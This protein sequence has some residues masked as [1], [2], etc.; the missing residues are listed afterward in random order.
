MR[1]YIKTVLQHPGIAGFFWRAGFNAISPSHLAYE[2]LPRHVE[3]G[4]QAGTLTVG[5]VATA[6]DII[7]GVVL[8]SVFAASTRNV[9][10]DYPEQMVG[11]ILLAL[12]VTRAVAAGQRLT[13]KPGCLQKE[14]QAIILF[15]FYNTRIMTEVPFGGGSQWTGRYS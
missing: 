14:V 8:A 6:I 13:Y 10:P 2:Y 7:A 15:A 4:I 12:G 11:H 9:P 1:L 3:D 5:D